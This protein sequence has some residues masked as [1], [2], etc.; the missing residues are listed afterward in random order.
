M[1]FIRPL[2]TLQNKISQK[3]EWVMLILI[4]RKKAK[5]LF[6]SFIKIAQDKS[7]KKALDLA[8]TETEIDS[9]LI[10]CKICLNINTHQD[11]SVVLVK[12]KVKS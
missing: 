6:V 9:G 10:V 12:V 8:P 4:S 7:W 5:I 1:A 3:L 2:N 11:S